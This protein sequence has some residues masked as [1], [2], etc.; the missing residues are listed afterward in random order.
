[1]EAK[2]MFAIKK[3]VLKAAFDDRET[4]IKLDLATDWQEV[5]KILKEFAEKHSFK[6]VQQ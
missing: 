1:M 5:Q 4:R 3:E 2:I 6:V